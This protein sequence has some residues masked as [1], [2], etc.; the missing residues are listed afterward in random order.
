LDTFE[1]NP[2][3]LGFLLKSIHER[4][5]AL[6][7]FQRDFVWQPRETE[8]LVES[9]AQAFP[10][11]SLLFM[12]YR[13]DTFTPREVHNAP[14]LTAAPLQLVLDGQQRLTSLY[15]AFYGAGEYRYFIDLNYCCGDEADIEEAVFYRHHTRG[16]RYDTIEKQAD[17]LVM[18]LGVVFGGGGFEGWF[19]SVLDHRPE[20]GD[21]RATLRK[22][23]REANDRFIKPIETY[24]FPV[25]T[26]DQRTSLEAV[27]SIF[28]TLN[29]TGVRLSVF[30]LL[31]ARY[32]AKGLDLRKKWQATLAEREIIAEF[33]VDEYYVLQAISLRAR[34]SVQRGEVLKLTKD[35]VE[36]HWDP[37]MRGFRGALEM[38]RADC[39]VLTARWLPYAYMLVPLAA[40]WDSA[41]E[42]AGPASGA[43]RE[44]LRQWFWCSALNARYDRAANTQ[45]GKD[46]NELGRWLRG[47][48]PPESVVEFAFDAERLRSITPRAQ[49]VYKA[50]MALVLRRQTLDFHHAS[51]LSPQTIASR[52]I[53]DHHIFPRAYLNPTDSEPVYPTE[54]VDCVLNRTMIDRDTNIRISNH[55]PSDYLGRIQAELVKLS[56]AQGTMDLLTRVLESHLLPTG[57][58]S[59]L[60]ADDFEGFL[61]WR[62]EQL[63][64]EI[65][66]ATGRSVVASSAELGELD[67]DA[68]A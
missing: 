47:G 45:A 5:L 29:K 46:F 16:G 54:V 35:E 50:L 56:P 18:P 68:V 23:L 62:Q 52:Q 25:V 27:C 22:R 41:I 13:P 14:T 34:R 20:Q 30:E 15:Q 3:S 67:L 49:S 6:P 9:I 53:D 64:R 40:L 65:E 21:D 66:R 2:K 57:S 42:V 61:D 37:V 51:P 63:A 8:A 38:L 4:A 31:A 36:E 24:Q 12:S 10:A 39:G 33:E 32:F 19:D 43:N 11:G 59:P 7:D 28:E 48:G 17:L 44:R 26:L 55:A 58:S 60:L 1:V